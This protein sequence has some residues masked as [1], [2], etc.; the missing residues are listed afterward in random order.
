[1]NQNVLLLSIALAVILM[2]GCASLRP[3]RYQGNGIWVR[4]DGTTYNAPAPIQVAYADIMDAN[5]KER[6]R[7]KEE[8]S[9]NDK[10]ETVIR[11]K[12]IVEY[13]VTVDVLVELENGETY[14][15]FFTGSGPRGA[16]TSATSSFSASNGY[17][18]SAVGLIYLQ[19]D[20]T[21]LQIR[22]SSRGPI[23]Y[24]NTLVYEP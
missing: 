22:I 9:T 4:G 15:L 23:N 13:D 8:R 18:Y 20:K 21:R 5:F 6:V 14:Q 7:V 19:P 1:M 11:E 17:S 16:T 3:D 10:G 12:E 24:Q 2:S